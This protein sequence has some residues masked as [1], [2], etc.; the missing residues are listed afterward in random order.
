[1]VHRDAPH[2]KDGTFSYICDYQS[3]YESMTS[4]DKLDNIGLSDTRRLV[5]ESVRM[6]SLNERNVSLDYDTCYQKAKKYSSRNEFHNNS[7]TAYSTAIKNGWMD[8]YT[9]FKPKGEKKWSRKACYDEAK[10]YKSKAEFSKN[11]RGAYAAAMKN[12]WMDDYTWFETLWEK[13]WNRETC[14]KEAQKY[15][16]QKEFQKNSAGAFHAAYKNGWLKDYIWFKR[17]EAYNKKW[18]RE[19]CAEE[20]RKYKTR[21]EF[22]KNSNSAY[23]VAWNNG[24]LDDY[25][26]LE[27]RDSKPNGYWTRERCFDE[28][29][30]YQSRKEFQ[31]SGTTAYHVARVHGWLDDYTWF[32][33]R[34]VSDKPIYLVYC[35]K[36]EDT[37]SVYVGLTNNVKERHKQ[38]RDG[39]VVHGERKFDIVY[40]YFHSIGKEPPEPIILKKELLA[41]DAQIYEGYYVELFKNEGM[42]VLNLAKPGSLGAYGKWDKESCEKEA[43]KYKTRKGFRDKSSQAYTV[44]R[45]NGWLDDYTWLE[46]LS[47]FLTRERC[48]DEAK[49]CK[50]RK[51]FQDKCGSA[52]R[53]ALKNGWLDD[54]TWFVSPLKTTKWTRDLCYD[55]AGK[56]KSRDEFCKNSKGAYA[57]AHKNGWMSDYTWLSPSQSAKKWDKESCYNEAQKYT[58][59]KDFQKNCG[60]AYNV[61][62]NNGWTKDYI[63][64]E[65]RNEA[66]HWTRENCY[67]EAKKYRSRTELARNNMSAYNVALRNGWLDDYSWFNE[68]KKRNYWNYDTCYY[69]AK[70]YKSSSEFAKNCSSACAVARKKGWIKDYTWFSKPFQWTRES[71]YD[72]AKKYKTKMDFNRGNRGAYTAAWKNGWLDDYT[73][74]PQGD[75]RFKKG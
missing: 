65:K 60:G 45:K 19:K 54:Y 55:E 57:A 1:M 67:N 23:N 37:N 61:A 40:R 32:K 8:D 70:K 50:T 42:N 48:F 38:H 75:G 52:Y 29:M 9:W 69:E 14:F 10:K 71:C 27:K 11:S 66:G 62:T 24:W 6:I 41:K 20:A 4:Q 44:A 12:R 15:K 17:P 39:I 34:I 5:S 46:R 13:K 64:L 18:T 3:S 74:F 63:W 7:R 49:K 59:L 56:Y 31:N 35:Y 26:W 33:R 73:W 51:E 25:T 36:D 16:S 22:Q 58:S 2:V 43:R 28:A 53:V 47:V 21:R 72:E 30:K 68:P